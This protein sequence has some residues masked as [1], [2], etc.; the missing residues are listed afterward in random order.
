[1]KRALIALTL[2]TAA[3]GLLAV[4]TQAAGPLRKWAAYGRPTR[5]HRA[6]ADHHGPNPGT[7]EA[8]ERHG[9]RVR[10]AR[11]ECRAVPGA[12]E[13]GPA[14]APHSLHSA[15]AAC[16]S[17]TPKPLD[18]CNSETH[19]TLTPKLVHL[20]VPVNPAIGSIPSSFITKST[21]LEPDC[22]PSHI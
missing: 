10:N 7:K 22:I 4:E 5:Q 11:T 3:I 12:Q 21:F 17:F 14:Q 9:Y 8:L 13:A 19:R 18:L 6:R 2:T 1:M 15:N 20:I 16:I